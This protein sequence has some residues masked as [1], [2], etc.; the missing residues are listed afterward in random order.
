MS[1]RIGKYQIQAELGFGGFGRVY[2][3]YDPSV[4]RLVA[5]KVLTYEGDADVLGRFR[6]EAA[7]TGN[8][9]HKNIV[10]LYDYGEH[11]GVPYL[12]MELLE[13]ENF[14]QIIYKHRP[15]SLLEKVGMMAQAA[16]G[17]N[18][19]HQH[20]VVHRDIKPSNIMLLPNGTVKIMDFGIARVTAQDTT[21]RTRKGDLL[22]TILYMSPEQFRGHDADELTDIFAYGIVYY[23]LL[24]GGHPFPGKDAGS[25]MYA[26]TNSD[27]EPLTTVIPDFPEALEA[28]VLKAM[29]RDREFRYQN[30]EDLL[31]DTAPILLDLRQAEA[32]RIATEL[33]SLVNTDQLETA[34]GKIKQ[35]LELDPGNADGRLW[36]EIVR[37][38]LQ[39]K[40][41]RVRVDALVQE[42]EAQL[43]QG[44][45]QEAIRALESA[46][47]LDKTNPLL[48]SR[49]ESA[50]ARQEAVRQARRLVSQARRELQ[51]N[52]LS[53]AY[54]TISSAVDADPQNTEAAKLREDLR[55]QIDRQEREARLKSG[56]LMADEKRAK[57]DYAGALAT[58][59]AI[60]REQPSSQLVLNL[61]TQVETERAEAARRLRAQQ[62]QA[63]MVQARF[64]VRDQ[65]LADAKQRL[66]FLCTQFP[67]EQAAADLL[68]EVHALLEA[69][70]RAQAISQLS[71]KARTLIKDK[72]FQEA[73][74][75]IEEGLREFSSDTGL[76]RLL[77][78]AIALQSAQERAEAIAKLLQQAQ[79]LSTSGNLDE[80]LQ[81][82]HGAIAR[83]GDETSLVELNRQL[84]FD[85]DQQRYAAGLRQ[86]LEEGRRLLA[87][88][89]AEEAVS[90]LEQ[91]VAAYPGESELALLLA[92]AR[93]AQADLQERRFVAQALA[94]AADLEQRKQWLEAQRQIE[95]ALGRYPQ[96]SD[97][98]QAAA[99]LRD[100]LRQEER[101]Q[102]IERHA[103]SIQKG[104]A[105]RDWA[106]AA[107]AVKVALEEFPRE[108]ALEPLAEVV[109]QGQLAARRRAEAIA[110]LSQRAQSLVKSKKFEEAL[111]ALKS[112][113]EDFPGD[114]GLQ[115][116]LDISTALQLAH[117][118]D[119]AIAKALAEARGFSQSG[120]LDKASQAI[121]AAL[122]RCGPEAKLL[123]FN[124]QLE[125]EREQQAYQAG[126]RQTLEEGKR[127]LAEGQADAAVTLL[128]GKVASYPRESELA[129][130]L[131]SARQVRA[132]Q[133]EQR[134]VQRILA[135][136]HDLAE[137][138]EHRAALQKVEDALRRYSWSSELTQAAE[139]LRDGLRKEEERRKIEAHTEGIQKAV[140]AQDWQRANAAAK[141][142]LAEFPGE[143]S[144]QDLAET[145][146]NRLQEAELEQLVGQGFAKNDLEDVERQL[147]VTRMMLG[148]T[149][150]WRDSQRELESR[151]AY[152][153]ALEEAGKRRA[154]GR[155][156]D[157]EEILRG[158]IA[159]NPL[160]NRAQ[161]LLDQISGERLKKQ[162]EEAVR[163]GREEAGRA[164]KQGDYAGALAVLDRLCLQFPERAELKTDRDKLQGM[165]DV[166]RKRKESEEQEKARQEAARREAARLEAERLEAERKRKESEEQEKAR[167]EAARREA[168]RLEA[169]R[170]EAERKRQEAEI[171]EKA[172]QEAAR[173][174]AARLEAE[175]L[176]AER[177]RKEVEEQ[178]KARKEAA[179]VEA[180]RKRKEAE[181]Q[182]K[183]RKDEAERKRKEVEEQEKA[184]KEAARVEAERKRKEAEQQEKARK[185]AARVVQ[186]APSPVPTPSP[187]RRPLY[188]QPAV[189]GGAGVAALAAVF[190]LFLGPKIVLDPKPSKLDFSYTMGAANPA[191]QTIDWGTVGAHFKIGTDQ[192]WLTAN[193][194]E[195]DRLE[196]LEVSVDPAKV[197]EPGRHPGSIHVV[198]GSKSTDVPVTLLVVGTQLDPVGLDFGT[199]QDGDPCP[200]P[201]K[202]TVRTSEP[203]DFTFS[204][205]PPQAA[206]WLHIAKAGQDG[207]T[208][209]VRPNNLQ[210]NRTW[211][212]K[213]AVEVPGTASASLPVKLYIKRNSNP[214]VKSLCR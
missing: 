149:L 116:L 55:E 97:L 183:A 206:Q 70:R 76:Q 37:Q 48:R 175:R 207:F 30:L 20:G 136:A 174:E 145:V 31:F 133:E 41:V 64:A 140:A 197:P 32:S 182:E 204:L 113:L 161:E 38:R 208:V 75:A 15:F 165:F 61:R 10:T 184:R 67:E 35:V 100:T 200:E 56:L 169:E 33:E 96:N 63:G 72:N 51:A 58:L 189:L 126:L 108:R 127:L 46:L 212:A 153:A 7:T 188:L 214:F 98:A 115:H 137:R 185:E 91:T 103:E 176:E 106:H 201:K 158:L 104:I 22:G 198:A 62:F 178:A 141:A 27:P 191:S 36:R 105:A 71:Q 147:T 125:F 68:K 26:I 209:E 129:I 195:G 47:T 74:Q 11:E 190:Y 8:L 150:V 80:A 128:E 213:I 87:E 9:I 107:A 186:P 42:A 114:A 155:L 102:K 132:E 134:F 146:R 211:E 2:R 19:A 60:E 69:Q 156:Q 148:E 179:R 154:Q 110:G 101:R 173:R 123:E 1:D 90:S 162:Q 18:L 135:E 82:V 94:D 50:R 78:A 194:S 89:H 203:A 24:T 85:R 119:Q 81:V 130:L 122:T 181:Q 151:R 25:V 39:H 44:A 77:D 163:N 121:A 45:F 66:E 166:E 124:R 168:A 12:V 21:R 6:A 88:G 23:E 99:R 202:V 95:R 143:K 34:Q 196:R 111:K 120:D 3:A 59:D 83:Y 93:Q 138:R 17:L 205:Q 160:D 118:R 144:L 139:T 109:R 142:A 117:E 49:L 187:A 73:R 86:A 28:V 172:R 53:A 193:L 170:L 180:E 54:E 159:Q 152:Q 210:M 14:H 164:L 167:Q 112:G 157:A 177:K 199:Y 192:P 84:E 79:A 57:G 92:N 52:N 29:A 131:A 5:I 13:G 171:Q 4:G 40:V 16:E 43:A 65:R